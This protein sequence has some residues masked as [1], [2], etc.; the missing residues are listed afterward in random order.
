[1]MTVAEIA[2]DCVALAKAG[3]L[4]GIGR[5]YWA[6]DVVSIEAM[7]GPMSRM[8]G[9]EALEGKA[10]WWYGAHDVHSVETFGPYVNGNQFAIRWTMDLT[11]KESGNRFQMDEVGLYTIHDGKIV[12]ERFFYHQ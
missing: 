5:K 4:D 1:M 8:Q 12:E 11:Q 7:E 2:A 6:D 10:A 3:D 9:R